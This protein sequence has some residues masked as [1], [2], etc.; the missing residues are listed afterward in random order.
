MVKIGPDSVELC[1]G[2]H[3][4]RAGDIGLFAIVSETGIAQ[5]VRRIEAVTGMGALSHLQNTSHI[6]AEAALELHAAGPQEVLPRLGR[7]FGDLKAR[8]REIADLQRKLAVGGSGGAGDSV[9]E[10]GG[11]KLLAKL[12]TVG[13]PKAL[14]DAAD[15]LRDRL[16]SGV[17]VLG[18]ERDGKAALLVAVT[19]DLGGKIHAGNLVAAIVGHVDGRGGGRP[20][21]AQAGGSN[22]QGLPAAL[23]AARDALAAQLA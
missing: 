20:D 6:L 10:V 1:G 3:V 5:G 14:R 2:T 22:P 8:E 18:A 16:G 7:L 9:V 4:A 15:A 13:D 19:K 23:A 11:V 21:L 12:V 17:V